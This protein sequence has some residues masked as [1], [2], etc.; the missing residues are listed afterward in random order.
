MLAAAEPSVEPR[1]LRD[2]SAG[3][4]RRRELV[5]RVAVAVE[6]ALLLAAWQVA[7][8]TLHLINPA[9]LPPPLAVARALAALVTDPRFPQNLA[10][11]L[12]NFALGVAIFGVAGIAVG[13]ALGA[14]LWLRTT[15]SPFVWA[16]YA[17]PRV[18]LAPIVILALGLGPPSKLA[19]VVLMG[20]F[21]VALTT[22]DGVRSVDPS[23]VR[24]GRVFGAR[25][26]RLA[27]RVYLP[28]AMP[29]V[30]VGLRR[31]VGLGFIGEMLGEFVGSS[32][33]LGLLLQ[34]AAYDF[35]M[36]DAFAVVVIMVAVANLSLGAVDLLRRRLAPWYEEPGGR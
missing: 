35:R 23:L 19:M 26:L 33:G 30:L 36:A 2:G 13:L 22:M 31:G 5:W 16:L 4:R 28:A 9:F 7:V 14:S 34:A 10:F 27:T 1:R 12:A 21:P 8:G 11:S 3:S 32:L 20:F 24:A 15:V 17:I 6:V 18:S 25:G 29:H